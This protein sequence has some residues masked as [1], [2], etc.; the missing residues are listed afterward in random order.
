MLSAGSALRS[1]YRLRRS[2][3][4][5][6]ASM[7][8]ATAGFGQLAHAVDDTALATTAVQHGCR[9]LEHFDAL[10]VVQVAHVLA[11]VA[12][13]VQVEVV[14]G[15]EATDAHAV[16][17]GIGAAA[18]VGDAAQRLAQVIGAVVRQVR[19]LH[20]VDGLGHIPHRGG[21]A[22]GGAGFLDARVIFV[23]FGADRR[24][25]ARWWGSAGKTGRQQG[26]KPKAIGRK[27][28]GAGIEKRIRHRYWGW[29]A[30]RN[31]NALHS[32][33][34]RGVIANPHR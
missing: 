22:G 24:W 4:P 20:R 8:G 2:S 15:V 28:E 9:A 1:A 5:P 12:N 29:K 27:T 30:A 14:A 19:G 16:E 25:Q 33:K 31:G 6:W 18:D 34:V 21:G 17:A 13:A 11:V 23:R 3:L 7:R 10:D 32:R 26:R